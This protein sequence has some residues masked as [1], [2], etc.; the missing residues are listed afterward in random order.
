[1]KGNEPEPCSMPGALLYVFTGIISCSPCNCVKRVLTF[2]EGKAV[3]EF[4]WWSKVPWILNSRQD[5]GKAL[6]LQGDHSYSILKVEN[7]FPLKFNVS[8]NRPFLFLK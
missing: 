5:G 7:C 6:R 2:I 8:K 1:M 3:K 4:K